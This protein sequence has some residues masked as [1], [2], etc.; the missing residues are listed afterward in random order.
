MAEILKAEDTTIERS[1]EEKLALAVCLSGCRDFYNEL[2]KMLV[3]YDKNLK[4]LTSPLYN[5][6]ASHCGFRSSD[7]TDYLAVKAFVNAN[8]YE[9]KGKL[10]HSQAGDENFSRPGTVL[11]K[12]REDLAKMQNSLEKMKLLLEDAKK[13][14]IGYKV[15][16]LKTT[17]AIYCG[18]NDCKK[19][20]EKGQNFCPQCGARIKW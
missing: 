14:E 8:Y 7:P 5:Y 1:P 6:L 15:Y 13:K 17:P 10:L 11:Y 3:I 18:N 4:F 9:K 16:R 20:I 12:V 2:S 19:K